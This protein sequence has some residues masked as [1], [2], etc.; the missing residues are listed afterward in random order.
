[1]AR[2]TVGAESVS[3]SPSATK[4]DKSRSLASS[5]TIVAYNYL[6]STF[7]YSNPSKLFFHSPLCHFYYSNDSLGILRLYKLFIRHRKAYNA[8]VIGNNSY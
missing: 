6:I 1:M 5:G 3:Y 7:N 2:F 8:R 4:V